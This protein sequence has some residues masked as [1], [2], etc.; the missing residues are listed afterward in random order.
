MG[1]MASAGL[2]GSLSFHLLAMLFSVLISALFFLMVKLV[3]GQT[4]DII[5]FPRMVGFHVAFWMDVY[6]GELLLCCV[7]CFVLVLF[8]F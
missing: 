2:Q 6:L 3:K 4:L 8:F 7:F 5:T 1:Y